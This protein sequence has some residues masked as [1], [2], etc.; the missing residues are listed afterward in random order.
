M[1]FRF[2]ILGTV[3]L[4]FFFGFTLIVKTHALVGF[5]FNTTVRIQNHIPKSLDTV[6]SFFSLLGSVEILSIALLIILIFHRKLLAF[7]SLLFFFFAQF[8]EIIG[9]SFLYHPGPPFRFFRYNLPFLFPSSY[10]Q[11]GSSY[12][13]G[14]SLRIV[15]V[16]LVFAYILQK[17]KR[18]PPATKTLL[19]FLIV[20][21][22]IIMLVTRVSLGE[23]WS[24][25]VIGGSLLGIGFG[26]FSLIF[27]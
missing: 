11:P 8:V 23:H 18:L 26:L 27:L 15:F 24:T 17:S 14:H 20:A 16:A 9:K 3:F 7:V 4:L 19:Q 1:K 25:D 13:S 6:M 21:F 2:L 22:T 5:D 12:P 10:V